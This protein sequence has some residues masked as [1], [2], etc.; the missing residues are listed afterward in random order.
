[1]TRLIGL[2]PQ[3]WRDRY[4]DEF[5]ALLAERPTG[6]ARTAWTSSAAP[7]TPAYIRRSRAR[8][9]APEPPADRARGR[10]RAGWLTLLGGVLWIAAFVA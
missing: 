7:S 10:R 9:V 6:S 5:L 2:Y 8:R 1:M 3:T 4:E